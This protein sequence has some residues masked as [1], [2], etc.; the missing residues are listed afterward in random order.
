MEHVGSWVLHRMMVLEAVRSVC[1]VAVWF[2]LSVCGID[3]SF[4][5]GVGGVCIS[6]LNV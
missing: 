1:L 4:P 2:Y 5:V 6:I 3:V